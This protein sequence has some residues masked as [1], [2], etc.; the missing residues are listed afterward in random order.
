M[1]ISARC[2]YACKALMELS[3]HWPAKEPM[4]IHAISERQKIPMRYLV[5]ILIQLKRMGLVDSVRGKLGGYNLARPPESISLGKVIREICGPLLPVANSAR[6]N[7]SVFSG[8]WMEVEEAMAT[9]LNKVTFEDILNKA[10]GKDR[11]LTY[12]I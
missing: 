8:V 11:V 6:E 1:R 7:K 10:K 4:Q 3:S 12:Y 5:Q 2:N 9:I